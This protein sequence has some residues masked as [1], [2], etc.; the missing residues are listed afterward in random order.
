MYNSCDCRSRAQL[1]AL[2]KDLLT[3]SNEK[4]STTPR[5]NND[6]ESPKPDLNTEESSA[7]KEESIPRDDPDKSPQIK[8]ELGL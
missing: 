8:P 5:V 4:N 1:E 7:V 3:E 2:I 6:D